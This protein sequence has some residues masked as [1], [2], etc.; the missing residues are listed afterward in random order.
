MHKVITLIPAL[1]CR[2]QI[3]KEQYVSDTVSQLE[4][5][6]RATGAM[7][8]PVSG[9]VSRGREVGWRDRPGEE[10]FR[11]RGP[12]CGVYHAYLAPWPTATELSLVKST[13]LK[14]LV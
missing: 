14:P 11:Q 12:P 2:R 13:F 4:S 7:E 1:W 5:R 3:V 8:K 6:T 10:G 9:G